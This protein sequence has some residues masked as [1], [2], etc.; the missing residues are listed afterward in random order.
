M[1][2]GLEH[3]AIAT[4]DPEKLAQ[5]YADT[6]SFRI[7]HRYAGNVFVRM[8]NGSL[9]EFIPSEGER[10]DLKLKS[11]GIRH[12]AIATDDFDAARAQLEAGNVRFLGDTIQIGDVRLAF[13]HD[14]EENVLHLI[15]RPNPLP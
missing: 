9:L 11:P 14:P 3:T 8:P 10:P 13:F 4:P 12:L 15:D 2:Q 5:W 7:V 1:F 6:F